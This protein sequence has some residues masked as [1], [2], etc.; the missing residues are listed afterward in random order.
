MPRNSIGAQAGPCKVCGAMRYA[1][2][3][4]VPMPDGTVQPV[5]VTVCT[6]CDRTV[7]RYA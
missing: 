5:V 6:A 1:V 2:R 3:Y 4:A 7:R